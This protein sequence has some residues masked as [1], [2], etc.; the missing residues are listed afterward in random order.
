MLYTICYAGHTMVYIIGIYHGILNDI[1]IRIY[2]G[3]YHNIF[4]SF[5][6]HW[7]LFPSSLPGEALFS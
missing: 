5:I 4:S 2:H 6:S 1:Y 7:I 3:I